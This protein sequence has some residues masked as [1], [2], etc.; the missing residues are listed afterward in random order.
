MMNILEVLFKQK[1]KSKEKN[2]SVSSSVVVGGA[3]GQ[4]HKGPPSDSLT[5]VGTAYKGGVNWWLQM[6]RFADG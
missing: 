1:S 4:R 5:E 2:F 3:V 6:I